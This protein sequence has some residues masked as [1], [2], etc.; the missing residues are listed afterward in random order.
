MVAALAVIVPTPN[1]TVETIE[2]QIAQHGGV[3]S[4]LREYV[5]RHRAEVVAAHH[6]GK[7]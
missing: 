5:E 1:D 6:Q 2:Q 3:E 7:A 4:Y